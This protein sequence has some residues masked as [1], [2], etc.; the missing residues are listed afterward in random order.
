M[1][2]CELELLG[3]LKGSAAAQKELLKRIDE[4]AKKLTENDPLKPPAVHYATAAERIAAEMKG[5]AA[6]YKMQ[7]LVSQKAKETRTQAMDLDVAS[8][9]NPEKAFRLQL[10]GVADAAEAAKNLAIA[11]LSADIEKAGLG[12]QFHSLSGKDDV[13]REAFAVELKQLNKKRNPKVGIT[14]NKEAL[15]LARIID[16]HSRALRAELKSMGFKTA[17]LEGRTFKQ[18]M[19]RESTLATAPDAKTFVALLKDRVDVIGDETAAEMGPARVEEALTARYNEILG[20]SISEPA[21]SIKDMTAERKTYAIRQGL[22]RVIHFKT[23]QDE[24]FVME[25]FGGGDLMSL[26]TST[27]GDLAKQAHL[28]RELG[29]NPRATTYAMIYHA[30]KELGGDASRIMA[31]AG[32]AGI[33]TP[34]NILNSINGFIDQEPANPKIELW[35]N[36][37]SNFAR[38]CYL[39]GASLN[40]VTDL[41]TLNNATRRHGIKAVGNIVNAARRMVTGLDIPKELAGE[42]GGIVEAESVHTLGAV[43]RYTTL[44]GLDHAIYNG[45]V[46]VADK[47]FTWNGLNR[48]TRA[49]KQTA[50]NQY[51]N[52]LANAIEARVPWASLPK[53]TQQLMIRAGMLDKDWAELLN[54]PNVVYVDGPMKFVNTAVLKPTLANR[55][56]AAVSRFVSGE[57]VLTPDTLSR[58]YLDMGLQRGTL[59]NAA[60]RQMT[61]LLGYPIAFIRQG[62]AREIEVNGFASFG[63]I[64]YAAALTFYG[65]IL[66]AV[67]DATSGRTRDYTDPEIMTQMF[68]AGVMRGGALTI[69]NETLV[70]ATGA[71]N[72]LHHLLFGDNAKYKTPNGAPFD[73]SDILVGGGVQ[74][75]WDVISGGGGSAYLALTGEA[76]K[77]VDRMIS[78]ARRT[79]PTF[80]PGAKAALDAYFFKYL[81]EMADSSVMQKAEQR[82]NARTGG[83]FLLTDFNP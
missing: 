49:L 19:T 25:K 22:S 52:M 59:P 74:W 12:P 33:Q 14:K 65:V 46:W 71:E 32:T 48:A 8:G 30:S 21:L 54:A 37:I 64:K 76:D 42:V 83:D 75:A 63:M 11:R 44:P 61:F 79:V 56:N 70:K 80:V 51:S 31:G 45:S 53:P 78:T 5:E 82:Y 17:D 16:R 41:P 1:D 28:T 43:H 47:T 10:G 57:A 29:V 40:S 6:D 62:I 20:T 50:Y 3:N 73:P 34:Q 69:Y 23:V 18:L 38:A 81:A 35:V 15:E 58:L 27:I 67:R 2:S 60:I 72:K 39:A 36:T 55:V 4:L 68:M 13:F 24:L 7:L 77:A 26:L 66:E 9:T